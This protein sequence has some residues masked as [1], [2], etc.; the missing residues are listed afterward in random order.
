MSDA[1]P[2]PLEP[3]RPGIVVGYDGSADADLAVR[4]AAREARARGCPL[5]LCLASEP[6]AAG[7][8]QEGGANGQ[9]PAADQ[10]VLAAGTELARRLSGGAQPRSM[11]V[12]GPAV[13]SLCELGRDAEMIVL[14]SRGRG[15]MPGMAI[16]S[17]SLY[18][19]AHAP[20]RVVIVRG[21]WQSV[22]RHAP[23][24]VIA[25]T[26]GSARSAPALTFAFE[27]AALR[28]TWV[29]AICALA[30]QAG[31]L[32]A[33]HEIERDFTELLA[34]HAESYPEVAVRRQVVPGSARPALL[35]ESA[36]AQ[37]MAV[38]AR[39]RGGFEGMA[40]GSVG[41]AIASYAACPVGIAR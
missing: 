18:V 9:P 8:P 28:D 24:P 40:L 13:A 23:Q 12:S 27:E 21:R 26:D 38:G 11:L 37:F 5:T 31:R 30:D 4:W 2:P 1:H 15:G 25:A 33:A 35:K 14:G 19:A 34:R 7:S 16:G 32:G 20:G 22:Q 29:L 36:R 41:M 10:E 6:A 17:V 3:G 39:G